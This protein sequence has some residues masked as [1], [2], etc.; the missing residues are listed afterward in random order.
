MT[1]IPSIMH[2]AR[3]ITWIFIISCELG[4]R[5]NYR[6]RKCFQR[7]HIQDTIPQTSPNDLMDIF[8]DQGGACPCSGLPVVGSDQLY[9]PS[10]EWMNN[11]LPCLE[12][13]IWFV[14]RAF[15][16]TDRS[17]HHFHEGKTSLDYNDEVTD[18]H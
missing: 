4:V 12:S 8:N 16:C 15:N 14:M 5:K 6:N 13:D 1:K 9:S 7:I 11:F 10:I 18:N 2:N 17:N 3:I